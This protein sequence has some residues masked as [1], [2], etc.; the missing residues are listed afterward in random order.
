MSWSDR[1][2]AQIDRFLRGIGRALG[3]NSKGAPGRIDESGGAGRSIVL[4][5]KHGGVYSSRDGSGLDEETS[6]AISTVND[7]LS[8][9][10]DGRATDIHMETRAS[11]VQLRF[12]IDGLLQQNRTLDH[13]TGRAVVSAIKVLADMDIAERRLPQDGTFALL[14]DGRRF[15]VRVGSIPGKYGEKLVIRLLDPGGGVLRGGL[16]ELG[17]RDSILLKVREIVNRPYGMLIVCGPAGHGKTTTAYGAI[18]EIDGTART[19]LTIRDSADLSLPDVPQRNPDV[20]LVDTIHDKETAEVA[21]QA[22]LTGHFVVATIAGPDTSAAVMGLVEFGIDAT[23]IQSAVT[24][25][26]AQRLWPTLCT[27]CK[28]GYTPSPEQLRRHGLSARRVS[29]LYRANPQGCGLCGGRGYLG[30]T[31]VYE[32]MVIG[33]EIRALLVGGPTEAEIRAAAVRQGMTTL[34]EEMLH[35]AETGVISLG[36]LGDDHDTDSGGVCVRV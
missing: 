35:K 9:A 29:K 27:R 32:L 17:F 12:R 19:N 34:V 33:E 21:V 8:D 36:D 7:L 4:L 30:R 5:K 3:M 25:V 16:S 20:I 24:A 26:L 31:G 2:A 28:V 18:S 1:L 15:E 13:A 10:I 14:A 23:M 11:E 6:Q 22:A